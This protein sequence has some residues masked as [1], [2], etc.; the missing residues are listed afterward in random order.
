[1][2]RIL[3]FAAA[4]LLSAAPLAA[5]QSTYMIQ[6]LDGYTGVAIARH[7]VSVSIGATP[8]DAKARRNILHLYTDERGVL[9]M[10]PLP[11]SG[12]AGYL[13]L[14][15][16][17]MHACTPHPEAGAFSLAQISA[18]GLQAPNACSKMAVKPSPGHFVI[19][20]RE[21]TA[22]EHAA[23]KPDPQH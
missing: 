9:L 3:L 10:P 15:T 7:A 12:P 23:L 22:A 14:W 17:D 19:F 16:A 13:Q 2:R 18:K 1:V 20:L 11:N 21:F 6:V 8:A 4:M 5:Q